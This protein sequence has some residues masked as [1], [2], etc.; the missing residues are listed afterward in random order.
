M[1]WSSFSRRRMAGAVFATAIAVVAIAGAWH[2][3]ALPLENFHLCTPAAA[4]PQAPDHDCLACKIAP[5]FAAPWSVS[6]K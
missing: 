3:H 4:A 1:T 6:A 5:P 2:D